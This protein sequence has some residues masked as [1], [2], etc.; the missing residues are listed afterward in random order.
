MKGECHSDPQAE[1]RLI[2]V[3]QSELYTTVTAFCACVCTLAL[4]LGLT[5]YRKLQ[6]SI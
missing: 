5:I 1:P 6:M 4:L 3:S 2:G